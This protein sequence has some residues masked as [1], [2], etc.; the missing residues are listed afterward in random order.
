VYLLLISLGGLLGAQN[1]QS[2]GLSIVT[3]QSFPSGAFPF[4]ERGH[5]TSIYVAEQDE[6]PVR[7]AVH[8]FAGDV[9]KVAGIRP[10][11]MATPTFHGERQIIIVGA[12]GHSPLLTQLS[13]RHLLDTSAIKGKWESALVVVVDK[14]F[15]GI[16]SAL[17]IAGS[18]ARGAAFALFDLSR[19]IGVSPWNWWADVPVQ[20]HA[21]AAVTQRSYIQKSPAVQ[22]RGIFINDE[23]WGIRPWA[24]QKM[25]SELK[26]I[27]PHTYARVFELL[28]RLHANTL[29]PAMH[30]GSLPFYSVSENTRLANQW[31][32]V[33]GS[34]HSEALLRNN[35]G[36]WD[37]GRD[38]QWNY[39]TNRE[40]IDR[41]WDERVKAIGSYEN[42]YTVG[43]RGQHDSGLKATGSTE[44]KARLVEQVVTDQRL[45]LAKRVNQN[46]A[47]VPQVIWLYK[48][49]IDLYR[50][51][52]KVPDDV[53]L[54]WTDD[55]YGYIR[56]L[57][58]AN[59]QQRLGGSALYYHVSYWGVPH[60]YLWLCSTPPALMREEL[61]KAWDHGVRKLWVLN[62]G[63]IKPAEQDID[64]FLKMAWQ[65]PEFRD[66]SEQGFMEGWYAE[67]FPVRFASRIARIMEQYDHLNFIRRPEFMGFNGYDDEIQRTAFNPLAWGD[68]NAQRVKAWQHLTGEAESLTAQLPSEY[69]N[70]YFELVGYPVEAAG[71]HNLKL[72]WND[73][74][75]L[76]QHRHD[77]PGVERDTKDARA[78]YNQVQE[79]TRQYNELVSGK[80]A[81]MMSSHPRDRRVFEMPETATVFATAPVQLPEDWNAGQAA[82]RVA[83]A[84]GFSEQ[85]DTVS[86]NATHFQSKRDTEQ[87]QWRVWPDLG[88]S[89]GSV[90]IADLGKA[91]E[92]SWTLPAQ[93]LS[94]DASIGTPFLDYAF[95]TTSNGDATGFIYL[96]PTF[97]IDSDHRL[98][99]GLSID[100]RVPVSL[101]AAET[102]G[103]K[104]NLSDW[105]LN[106]LRNAMV[107]SVPLGHLAAGKHTLRLFYGDPGLVFEHITIVFPGAPPA[108]PFA[109]ETGNLTLFIAPQ[110]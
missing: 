107:Q 96:L 34:S 79:L 28:L 89:G 51:G 14:P 42:F 35:V 27:G 36:E 93:A 29:W 59:E 16:Q 48:E 104:P 71:A 10:V 13:E 50:A 66:V 67:Q 23:D 33:M 24:A 100:G 83:Q 41:Y 88:L 108:Y 106:V 109:P 84:A 101:D 92:A 55:N 5:A 12:L 94:T 110:K 95:T 87:G 75:Y 61:T 17:V 4:F 44:V 62:V 11:T 64:Y 26:N 69:R 9:E 1:L 103:H 90:S 2:S 8:A 73:R 54:G 99:Y 32:I 20:H 43:M 74:S 98:R 105:S 15:P 77:Y 72:L 22:Y 45:I 82:P 6:A 38:G 65:V 97:P 3:D 21:S 78:A 58:N 60:D 91:R 56:Q 85:S 81:G 52:M 49:S 68:Q 47:K 40:A 37:E 7:T 31:G 57:P 30:P 102:E 63:D 25:D 46:L 70:T 86:I 18:D 76:D 39:Q 53:T 80:W 19:A